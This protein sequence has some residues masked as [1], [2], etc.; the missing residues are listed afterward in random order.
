MNNLKIRHVAYIATVLICVDSLL[1]INFLGFFLQ[2]GI[3]AALIGLAATYVAKI[4]A[5]NTPDL[6][7]WLLAV[8]IALHYALALDIKTFLS[9]AAYPATF[10]AIYL[11]IRRIHPYVNWQRIA[12]TAV[13]V[14]LA[15]G[16]LQYL[17]I[18]VFEI[19]IELRGIDYTYYEGKGTLGSRMRGFF[20]EPNWF[21]LSLF[22]WSFLYIYKIESLKK[23]DALIIFFVIIA[24]YLSNNR[25]IYLLCIYML[26]IA[27]ASTR[28]PKIA[29]IAPAAS[30]F[31]A[32]TLF[33][34]ISSYY[35]EIAD[36]SAAA[37]TYT[38]A[39]TWQ[40]WTESELLTQIVG[41]GFSNWGHYSNNWALSWSNYRL[42]QAL[43]RRDN[44]EIYVF[45]FEMGALSFVIFAADL[46]IIGR[47]A[48]KPI[49]AAFIGAIYIASLF[50]PLYQFLI[51]LI[52]LMVVRHEILTQPPPHQ[53][54]SLD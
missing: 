51:Y 16:Y 7:V 14:L 5:K 40:V 33:I 42:D 12:R 45:L 9:C 49:A 46:L 15:T 1:K 35:P 38:M 36:R 6:I 26:A 48:L 29:K 23:S 39:K 53:H 24:I 37:R 30:V 8:Y 34:L 21:G 4:K 31:L 44:A 54:H 22:A 13:L 20:L 19:Q 50:Y 10:G 17:L 43:T 27:F 47:R 11:F 52:P 41:Y 18:N 3:L 25:L 32:C 28:L 2:A